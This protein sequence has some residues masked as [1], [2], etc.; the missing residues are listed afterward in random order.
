MKKI[1]PLLAILCLSLTNT[2]TAQENQS[3]NEQLRAHLHK[4]Y[5]TLNLLIQSE[6]RYS[7]QDDNFQGGRSFNATN[8][9]VSMRG[10]LNGGFFYR[11]FADAAPQ[12]VLLDAYAGYKHSDAF[13]FMI[14]SMKPRQTLDY[15]P[16]PASYNFVDRATITGLLVGSREIGVA[17]TG[18]IGGFYYYTG[19]FNG[20]GLN[21]NNNNKF[22]GI[23]RLQYTIKKDL[24]GYIQFALSGSHGNSEGTPSGSSGPL[25]RGKRSIFGSDIEIALNRLY[26]AAEYLQGNLQTTDLPNANELISGYY[27]TGGWRF[28]KKTMSFARWQSYSYKEAGTTESKL[29][30]GT[31]I[32]FTDIVGL[33]C[34]LDAFMPNEGDTKYGASFIFQVQF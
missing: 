1:V 17:A 9:R 10:I 20:N 6:G 4:D 29:T 32:N 11:L 5:F 19:L 33:V 18:D 24:P 28:S 13:R 8:A 22:Y 2:T 34:N 12:P 3:L 31:N 30:M 7:F 26:L 21:S 27:F 23:G 15:I 16:D 25:L 14:G